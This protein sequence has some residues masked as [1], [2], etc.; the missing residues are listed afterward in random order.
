MVVPDVKHV[1]VLRDEIPGERDQTHARFDQPPGHQK[2]LAVFVAAVAITD[3]RRL[4]VD[5]KLAFG[6]RR[7]QHSKRLLSITVDPASRLLLLHRSINR[8]NRAEQPEPQLQS[9][10]VNSRRQ[11]KIVRSFLVHFGGWLRF[12]RVILRTEEPRVSPRIDNT[13]MPDRS[14]NRHT[15]RNAAGGREVSHDRTERREIAAIASVPWHGQRVVHSTGE[16]VI[17][18]RLVVVAGMRQRA[19]D[20]HLVRVLGNLRQVLADLNAGDDRIDR[21]EQTANP[22]GSIRFQIK[23]VVLRRPAPQ[24]HQN[25]RLSLAQPART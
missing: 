4:V 16:R 22:F 11:I 3:L 17:D 5:P 19:N 23:R 9:M 10:L 7:G 12:D 20:R 13:V 24:I 15:R 2:T 6:F 1:A 8:L 18:T 14:R 25:A 21:V